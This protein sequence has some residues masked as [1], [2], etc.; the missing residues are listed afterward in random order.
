[1]THE[2]TS[3]TIDDTKHAAEIV[4]SLPPEEREQVQIKDGHIT[5][6][7]LL[8]KKVQDLMA[9]DKSGGPSGD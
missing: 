8:V 5:G 3:A 9:R 2:T 7:T 4:R 1:M 6:A